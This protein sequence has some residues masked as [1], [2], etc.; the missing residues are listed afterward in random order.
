MATEMTAADE[1]HDVK[2]TRNRTETNVIRDNER[3]DGEPWNP[4]EVVKDEKSDATITLPENIISLL[5]VNSLSN[6]KLWKDV[7]ALFINFVPLV[8]T[9]AIQITIIAALGNVVH[10]ENSEGGDLAGSCGIG[11]ER[12]SWTLVLACTCLFVGV[13]YGDAKENLSILSWLDAF[14]AAKRT[15][16]NKSGYVV[17]PE[18]LKFQKY[19]SEL[20]GRQIEYHRPASGIQERQ[21]WLLRIPVILQLVV[22]AMVLIFGTQVILLSMSN[23]N[24]IL[25]SVALQFV[26]DCDEIAFKVFVD[27]HSKSVLEAVPP[28]LVQ[29][30]SGICIDRLKDARKYIMLGGPW[31]IFLFGFVFQNFCILGSCDVE[32]CW[33]YNSGNSTT[34]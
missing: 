23:I 2:L 16:G 10:E 28:I 1:N 30:Q 15:E 19:K 34:T 3:E 31:V 7:E 9:L 13:C 24:V 21:D 22:D 11:D 29:G 18:V 20:H 6:S 14:K 27:N 5:I 33:G 17:E 25:N 12:V 26:L 8:A 4:E 32:G